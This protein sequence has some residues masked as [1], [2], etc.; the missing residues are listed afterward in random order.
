MWNVLWS[1]HGIEVKSYRTT[2][3]ECKVNATWKF[4]LQKKLW[5]KK[6]SILFQG[7]SFTAKMLPNPADNNCKIKVAVRVRPFNRRGKGQIPRFLS[8]M[9]LSGMIKSCKSINIDL[10]WRRSSNDT[11]SATGWTRRTWPMIHNFSFFKLCALRFMLCGKE[12][13]T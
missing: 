2:C 9:T 1:W 4:W 13:A 5:K 12:T 6:K 11:R 10:D 8:T 3:R 7:D